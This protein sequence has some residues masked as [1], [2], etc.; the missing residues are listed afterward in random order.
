MQVECMIVCKIRAVSE[1]IRDLCERTGIGCKLSM[2]L[3]I[4]S[5]FNLLSPYPFAVS[6]YRLVCTGLQAI[7]HAAV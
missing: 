1:W 5:E 6:P 4:R 2:T 3:R 7:Y